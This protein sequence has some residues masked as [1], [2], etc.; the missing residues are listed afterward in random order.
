MISKIFLANNKV[1]KAIIINT[2]NDLKLK[3]KPLLDTIEFYLKMKQGLDPY[4]V[5]IFFRSLAKNTFK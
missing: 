2:Y 1:R 4:K 5:Q 3:K